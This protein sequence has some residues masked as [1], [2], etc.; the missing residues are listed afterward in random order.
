MLFA[1]VRLLVLL[2]LQQ[3]RLALLLLAEGR[4]VLP[5]QEL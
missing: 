1:V 5:D 4:D 2:L 3:F